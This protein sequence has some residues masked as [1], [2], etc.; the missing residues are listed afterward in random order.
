MKTI[1]ERTAT[2][3]PNIEQA[4]IDLNQNFGAIETHTIRLVT[5]RIVYQYLTDGNKPHNTRVFD[6]ATG[7]DKEHGNPSFFWFLQKVR[8]MSV[9]VRNGYFKP[10]QL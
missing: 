8:K 4:R 6:P 2:V 9:Q 5:G 1:N 7:E 10:E 3:Y